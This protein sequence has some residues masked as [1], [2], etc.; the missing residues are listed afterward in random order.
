MNNISHRLQKHVGSLPGRQ[1]Q[2]QVHI[3]ARGNAMIKAPVGQL[4]EH[5][6]ALVV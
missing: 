1:S 4:K 5:L 3:S 6:C 2:L